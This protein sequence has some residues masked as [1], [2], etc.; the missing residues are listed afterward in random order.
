MRASRTRL[1]SVAFVLVVVIVAL[2]GCSGPEL[3]PPQVSPM[4]TATST[5]ISPA[6][7]ARLAA[8]A[9]I[10]ADADAFDALVAPDRRVRA[11]QGSGIAIGPAE[12]ALMS[13]CR[14]IE[15]QALVRDEG[16]SVT[17]L[18][19]S[20]CIGSDGGLKDRL[21]FDLGQVNGEWRIADMECPGCE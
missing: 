15:A 20:P 10:D 6:D 4:L 11:G 12:A 13:G 3:N 18:Y 9:I 17:L 1:S 2:A 19:A 14:G 7:V 16:R 5:D 8:Q 21:V